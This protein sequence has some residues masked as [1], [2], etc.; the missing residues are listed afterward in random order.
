[1]NISKYLFKFIL[2]YCS[3]SLTRMLKFALKLSIRQGNINLG[4]EGEPGILL[5][6]SLIILSP[7]NS[8]PS[9]NS[10]TPDRF[11]TGATVIQNP[12]VMLSTY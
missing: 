12:Q 3:K 7:G 5:F 6:S 4:V 2:H 9:L 11:I 1:M 10:P 8:F